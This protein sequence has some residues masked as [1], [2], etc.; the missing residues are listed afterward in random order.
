[1]DVLSALRKVTTSIKTWA[2]SK[3][4]TKLD[5]NLGTDNIGKVIAVDASGNISPSNTHIDAD[6]NSWFA[7]N[8]KVGGTGQDD[9]NAK[10]L[11]T[12]NDIESRVASLVNSAPETLDTLN[13]LAEALGNDPNFATTVAT[14]IGKKVDKVDGKGLSTN[15]YTDEEKE[16]LNNIS[17]SDWNATEGNTQILNKPTKLSQFEGEMTA[18]E[19]TAVREKIGIN[20]LSSNEVYVMD[21]SDTEADIPKSV[22]LII[23]PSEDGEPANVLKGEKGDPFTYEDFT[24]EQL[25]SLKGDKGDTGDTPQLSVGTVTTVPSTES[26]SASMTGTAEKPVLNLRIPKGSVG[27]G[28]V[29]PDK[30]TW[31]RRV[32]HNIFD[33]GTVSDGYFFFNTTWYQRKI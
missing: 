16:K 20:E 29:D 4:E 10:Q 27:D 21:E 11:A 32:Y 28:E 2:D 17:Q 13:E 19:Q 22:E 18:D 8:V 15:D 3:L 7:G 6:G 14:E 30:T 31:M 1:M 25:A 26:A 5:K 33:K 9:S 12:L 24:T 23:I